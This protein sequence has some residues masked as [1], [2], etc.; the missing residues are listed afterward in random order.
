MRIIGI[1]SGL[2]ALAMSFMSTVSILGTIRLTETAPEVLIHALMVLFGC[3]AATLFI[4]EIKLFWIKNILKKLLINFLVSF[5]FQ[6]LFIKVILPIGIFAWIG[7]IPVLLSGAVCA[8]YFMPSP[9]SPYYNHGRPRSRF[10]TLSAPVR[11]RIRVGTA[12]F[13]ALY[14]IYF[15][16]MSNSPA[17]Q[18]H[19]K[20]SVV[21]RQ[22]YIS[23]PYQDITPASFRLFVQSDLTFTPNGFLSFEQ[24]AF[25]SDNPCSLPYSFDTR[26]TVVFDANKLEMESRFFTKVGGFLGGWLGGAVEGRYQ[27]RDNEYLLPETY[28]SG[29]GMGTAIL[30]GVGKLAG[31]YLDV[32]VR[33]NAIAMFRKCEMEVVSVTSDTLIANFFCKECIIG[34][35]LDS[36]YVKVV[37]VKEKE[38]E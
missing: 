19:G 23:A 9:N 29:P 2:L 36:P 37:Y 13:A 6:I 28:D 7:W 20:W 30:G 34:T 26:H 4:I 31:A 8:A 38:E 21:A 16:Y 3:I 14:G 25:L 32:Q 10:S 1:L 18:I 35:P 24:A 17:W 5:L 33:E 12:V 27:T 22:W 11:Q 15:V